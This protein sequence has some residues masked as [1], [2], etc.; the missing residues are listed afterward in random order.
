MAGKFRKRW[1]ESH[2]KSQRGTEESPLMKAA[3]IVIALGLAWLL[4]KGFH[5][6]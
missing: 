2:A 3:L 5:W 1:A 4:A 6:L